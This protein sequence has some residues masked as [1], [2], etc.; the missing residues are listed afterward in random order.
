ML[1]FASAGVSGFEAEALVTARGTTRAIIVLANYAVKDL[2]VLFAPLLAL[3]RS[4][5]ARTARTCLE[6]EGASIRHEEHQTQGRKADQSGSE[7]E[8]HLESLQPSCST[9]R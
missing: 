3:N 9:V 2:L 4:L 6:V 5:E 7:F 8:Q 1:P